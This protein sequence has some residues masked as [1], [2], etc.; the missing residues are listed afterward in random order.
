MIIICIFS[1]PQGGAPYPPANAAAAYPPGNQGGAVYPPPNQQ[2]PMSGPPSYRS[3]PP[4]YNGK[5]TPPELPPNHPSQSQQPSAPR[6]DIPTLPDLPDLPAIPS[7]TVPGG[8]SVGGQSV[9]FDDLTKR[10]EE[11]KKRK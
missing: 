5:V 9:D 11:L 3:E 4:G 10:F 7:D 6:N 8:A 1:Q 2:V